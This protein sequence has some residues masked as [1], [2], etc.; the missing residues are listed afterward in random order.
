MRQIDGRLSE[1]SGTHD[2]LTALR[3]TD[4]DVRKSLYQ[5]AIAGLSTGTM[6]VK[7]R[8]NGSDVYEA[9]DNN[10]IDRKSVV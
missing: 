4:L 1:V 2:G 6:T 9:I 10:T 5:V 3:V 8:T 7:V